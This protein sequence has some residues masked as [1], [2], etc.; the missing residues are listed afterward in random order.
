MSFNQVDIPIASVTADKFIFKNLSQPYNNEIISE[1]HILHKC[2]DYI[3]LD[4]N[5]TAEKVIKQ[6]KLTYILKVKIIL[7]RYHW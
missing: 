5:I 1:I 3:F 2:Y 4:K 6:L 7:K